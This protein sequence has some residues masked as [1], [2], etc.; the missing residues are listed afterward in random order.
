MKK[1]VF[2]PLMLAGMFMIFTSCQSKKKKDDEAKLKA[3]QELLLKAQG[4]FKSLPKVAENPDNEITDAKVLLGKVLYFDVAL[5]KDNKISC[6]SCHNLSTYG[7]DNLPV[8]PGNDGKNGTRNS[9][10][11]LNAALDFVQFWDGRN[12]DVE[13]QA[14]GPI[15]NPVEMAMPNEKAVV[16][17]IKKDSKYQKLFADAYPGQKDP[18]TFENIRKAIAAFE[19]TLMTPSKFDEFLS[20][21]T[22]ALNDDEQK[23]LATFMDQGCTTCHIGQNLGGT[24]FHKF[25][26]FGNYWEMTQSKNIDNGRFDVTKNEADKYFFKVSG[27]RNIEK[28]FPYFHDGS[29]A[30]L[31]DAVKIMAKLQLNKDLTEE[32]TA[33]IVTFLKTLTASIPEDWAK[34]PEIK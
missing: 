14:G 13:E 34:A 25:G 3:S 27:L 8:S 6:N 7:V 21:K 20:G 1:S 33:D 26:L 22:E 11:V 24:M 15:L 9:P 18:F 32:Q 30:K 19:R 28:T 5:S 4:F 17:K 2:V 23:G 16:D 10:T 31:D 12:K 29:V